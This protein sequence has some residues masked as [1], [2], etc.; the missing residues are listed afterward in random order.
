ME[1]AP[2]L[3]TK[4]TVED[5]KLLD[6]AAED[7]AGTSAPAGVKVQHDPAERAKVQEW[8]FEDA[9]ETEARRWLPNLAGE[10]D[11]SSSEDEEGDRE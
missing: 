4:P 11:E 3:E 6:A 9:R 5:Q 2:A 1:P 10:M 8:E 7:D